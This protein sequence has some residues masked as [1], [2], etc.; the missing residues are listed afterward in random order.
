MKIILETQGF[1]IDEIE[2]PD[3]GGHP[4]EVIQVPVFCDLHASYHL[5]TFKM[6]QFHDDFCRYERVLV[7]A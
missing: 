1:K 6:T 7:G 5:G 2:L 4:L 3:V